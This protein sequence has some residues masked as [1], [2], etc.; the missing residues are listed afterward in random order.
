[1]KTLRTIFAAVVVLTTASCLNDDNYQAGF[2]FSHPSSQ[3]ITA[4]ANNVA[5]TISLFSYGSWAV[6]CEDGNNDNWCVL[7]TTKGYG[8]TNYNFPVSF[9]QNTTG[10]PRKAQ[11]KFYDT[12]HPEEANAELL[13]W[14]YATRGDGTLG[15]AADVKAISG[16]DGSRFELTYDTQH[17]PLSLRITK[18]ATLLHSMN[19]SYNDSIMTVQHGS[20]M[21]TATMDSDYQ[22][23]TLIG[24]GDT[25]GYQSQYYS[26]GYPVSANYAF[27][28]AH[29]TING[30][31]TYYAYLLN[32]QSLLP[33]SLHCADSLNTATI[34]DATIS[35]KKMKFVYSKLDNRCQSVDVN[36]LAFG[37]E[38]C[39][40]YQLL[41]F[42]RYTRNTS[43]VKEVWCD[44]GNVNLIELK[45]NTDRSVNEM[46]V[47]FEGKDASTPV[48]ESVTYTFEY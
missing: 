19:I 37:T 31:N 5:E 24:S 15:N 45:L 1:M 3:V 47:T 12:N 7:A 36:Q 39:D 22:P 10:T 9:N 48:P 14:Q 11:F 40:P 34:T 27:N 4:Y 26:N 46:T 33:D 41:S 23:Q 21:L 16:T 18:N 2:V 30:H 35:I 42:F 20:K 17:R 25:I 8:D 13:Y 6:K 32:G 43:I 29:R 28:L 38:Q 44:D